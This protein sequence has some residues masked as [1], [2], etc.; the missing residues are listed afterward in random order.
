MVVVTLSHR[1]NL[2]GHLYLAGI[3]PGFED[4]GNVGIL[5]LVLALQWVRENIE[6][7]GGDPQRVTIFGQSG[8]GAKCATLMGM[9]AAHGLFHRVLSMSGQQ[10]TASR[11][12]SAT[13]RAQ[14]VLKALDLPE[15]RA[16]EILHLPM[17]Q[18]IAASSAASYYGPVQDGRSLPSNPFD[19]AAPAISASI[20]MIL[21]NT[22]DET[23]LLIGGSDP[24]LFQLTWEALPGSLK[25]ISAFLGSLGPEEV[26]RQY[27]AIYPERS[28]A[29]LFF[30]ITTG[31]R[32]WRGQLIEAERRALQP[33]AARH[34]WVYELDWK[35]PVEAGR[36]GA[37]H[38]LDIP[39][40][41][42]NT[43][44]A[45]GMSGDGA[46]ARQMATIMSQ[47]LL[48]F[49]ATGNPNHPEL[50]EWPQYSLQSRETMSFDLPPRAVSDPRRAERQLIE[51]VPYTQP[52]T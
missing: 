41:F 13:E 19:P 35:S 33:E 30:A 11:P 28:P 39:L 45:P 52:G 4:S 42:D 18:L 44:L 7:F 23:R 17:P 29:D 38:T 37:P 43:A 14:M 51:T 40:M 6:E 47:T 49:A 22:H 21:G 36:W 5:D 15:S 9:P 50:P 46:A 1:L 27:R 3:A 16:A 48:A 8:G 12:E 10:I 25:R 24:A 31:F 32:S 2:F 26:V 34:T 20:P